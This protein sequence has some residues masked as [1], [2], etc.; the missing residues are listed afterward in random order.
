MDSGKPMNLTDFRVYHALRAHAEQNNLVRLPQNLIAER[1]GIAPSNFSA[2]VKRLCAM[3]LIE[4][5]GKIGRS[6]PIRIS[7][8]T[9]WKGY[10]EDHLIEL[11]M[12]MRKP[13]RKV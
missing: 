12:A 9:A 8:K 7:P 6:T 5:Q 4:K 3:G 1:V 2:S 11:G 10:A 13:S